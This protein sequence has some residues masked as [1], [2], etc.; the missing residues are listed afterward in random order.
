M[1]TREEFLKWYDKM[2]GRFFP[3]DF[4]WVRRDEVKVGDTIWS[5]HSG[6]RSVT[7]TSSSGETTTLRLADNSLFTE[8]YPSDSHVPRLTGSNASLSAA[9]EILRAFHRQGDIPGSTDHSCSICHQ[10][11]PCA[12]ERALDVVRRAVTVARR[13]LPDINEWEE[14]GRSWE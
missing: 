1:T 11:W 14:N 12:T 4:E 10:A 9:L 13:P 5:S 7:G 3:Y 8:S 2:Y 6:C